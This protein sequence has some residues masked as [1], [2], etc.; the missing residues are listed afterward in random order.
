MPSP[1]SLIFFLLIIS[2]ISLCIILL[3]SFS[4]WIALIFFLLFLGGILILFS[5]IRIISPN[6]KTSLNFKIFFLFPLYLLIR[7]NLTFNIYL[8][9][10]RINLNNI[11]PSKIINIPFLT[12]SYFIF[13]LLFIFIV[14]ISNLIIKSTGPLRL[15]N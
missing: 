1:L 11:I 2:L 4:S 12:L 3:N 6:E 5:Y 15:S 9:F 7:A 13:I 10:L 8:N 14:L